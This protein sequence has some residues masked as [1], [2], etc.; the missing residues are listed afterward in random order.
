MQAIVLALKKFHPY[1]L[2]NKVTIYAN[3]SAMKHLLSKNDL[4]PRLIIWVLLQ[5]E[6]QLEFKDK[7]AAEN[8]VADHLNRLENEESGIPFSDCS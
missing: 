1:L 4:K 5:E 8:L 7:Q 3:Y 6:F 2:G